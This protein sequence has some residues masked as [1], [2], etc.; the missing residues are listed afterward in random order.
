MSRDSYGLCDTATKACFRPAHNRVVI[1]HTSSIKAHHN[2][3]ISPRSPNRSM[4]LWLFL[5]L[6]AARLPY[7]NSS[8]LTDKYCARPLSRVARPQPAS[9]GA[10]LAVKRGRSF[11]QHVGFRTSKTSVQC[12]QYGLSCRSTTWYPPTLK[13]SSATAAISPALRYLPNQEMS[14][15]CVL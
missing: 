15:N 8:Q 7:S 3:T 10:L 6:L 12:L 1:A 14:R 11:G 4:W 13:S 2:R 9:A 5:W